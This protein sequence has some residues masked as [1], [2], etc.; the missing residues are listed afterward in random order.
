MSDTIPAGTETATHDAPGQ[1]A[2]EPIDPA[3]APPPSEADAVYEWITGLPL[4]RT[5]E[6][7]LSDAPPPIRPARAIA[8][9]L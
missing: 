7:A 4:G 8:F 5:Q 1:R 6:S 3:E 2:P 9:G